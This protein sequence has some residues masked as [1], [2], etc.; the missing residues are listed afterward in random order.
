MSALTLQ[1]INLSVR[2]E[3]WLDDIS[4]HLEP[5]ALYTLLGRTGA[6]K[7][8]LIRAI[9]G[10]EALDAGHIEHG[11]RRWDGL[12]PWRR[13]VAMV[14][15]QFI[16]YP[17][18]SVL[19]NVAFP[20]RRAGV[21]AAP[22]RERAWQTIE[23][24]GLAAMADRRPGALSGGQ[25]QRVAIARALTKD[26]PVLLLDEPLVNLDY[27]LREQM[28]EDL[29]ELLEGRRSTIVIYASTEPSEA[30]Q[31]SARLLVMEEGRV[32]QE[33]PPRAVFDAPASVGAARVVNDPPVNILSMTL[34]S[35]AAEVESLGWFSLETLFGV[36]RLGLLGDQ[37]LSPGQYYLG[38]RASDL[39]LAPEGRPAVVTLTEVSGSETVT[40]LDMAGCHLVLHER[41]VV[42]H[43]VGSQIHIRPRLSTVFVFDRNGRRVHVAH[44]G[45]RADS[46]Q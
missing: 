21:A 15:Q 16:N 30:L 5:G 31:M 22:A 1:N 35:D 6:G 2:D 20:L 28:R 38:L 36:E 34:D 24:V 41:A 27:K 13:P 43:P 4:L 8:S 9:A 7:T 26:A 39:A 32:V 44:P 18:L 12:A 10:L 3:T 40:H 33:G 46:R 14:Y 29:V 11:G 25:Q 45:R 19:D 42:N 37:G 23:R 17:H